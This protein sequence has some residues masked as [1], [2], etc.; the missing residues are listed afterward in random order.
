MDDVD[1]LK[2]WGKFGVGDLESPKAFD[3]LQSLHDS[4][5]PP[6]AEARL[7]SE[8]AVQTPRSGEV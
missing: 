6:K 7:G 5:P 8:Q 3:S 2:Q 1:D 4:S